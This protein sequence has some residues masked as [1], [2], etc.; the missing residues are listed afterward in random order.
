MLSIRREIQDVING[1]IAV[2]DSPLKG[3]LIGAVVMLDADKND[4]LVLI[5]IFYI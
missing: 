1:S 5:I 4:Y 3:R 2:T